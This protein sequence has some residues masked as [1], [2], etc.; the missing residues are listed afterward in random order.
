MVAWLPRL[1]ADLLDGLHFAEGLLRPWEHGPRRAYAYD[2]LAFV[3]QQLWCVVKSRSAPTFKVAHAVLRERGFLLPLSTQSARRGLEKI[4]AAA[5]REQRAA[6]N[7]APASAGPVCQ[8]H[9][10]IALFLSW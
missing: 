9:P 10:A 1:I 6:P 7:A 2:A 4:R 8:A 3:H 5:L